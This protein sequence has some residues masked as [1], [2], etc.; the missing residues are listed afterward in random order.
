MEE[1]LIKE[2]KNNNASN[3]FFGRIT[4]TFSD[5]YEG[6]GSFGEFAKTREN[7]VNKI[8]EDIF[9]ILYGPSY[10][11]KKAKLKTVKSKIKNIILINYNIFYKYFFRK[12]KHL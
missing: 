10:K 3:D 6:K 1:N 11:D 8:K 4:R 12:T 5:M 7:Q 2:K 9:C